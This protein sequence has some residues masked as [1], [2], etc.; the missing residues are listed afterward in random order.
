MKANKDINSIYWITIDTKYQTDGKG[1][2]LYTLK[3]YKDL[4]KFLDAEGHTIKKINA[5]L[6]DI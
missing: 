1:R 2:I 6:G 3:E 5:E 4:V